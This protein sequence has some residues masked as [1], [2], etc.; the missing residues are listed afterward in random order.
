MIPTEMLRSG[1]AEMNIA[2]T[3]HQLAQFDQYAALLTEWNEKMNLTGITDPEAI[4]VRHFLDSLSV[5]ACTEVPQGA[6]VVD[7]G[8]GAGFPGIPLKIARPDLRITLLDSLNKRLIFLRAVCDELRLTTA[9]LHIRAEE[10]GRNPAL[11]AQFDLA[12]ARAVAALPV[13]AE[14]CVPFVRKGGVFVAMKGPD[15]GAEC[16][17]AEPAIR[18]L[19]GRVER[20]AERTLPDGSGRTLIVVRKTAPTPPAY[21][22]AAAKIAKAPLGGAGR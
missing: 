5:L 14:Y 22:R 13:L 21:P 12:T 16:A 3:D 11:R 1:A 2:L 9:L 8:T 4:V 18:T 15:C 17:A 6:S 7:V 10:G 19:G 20:T